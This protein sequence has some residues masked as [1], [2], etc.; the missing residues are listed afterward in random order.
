LRFEQSGEKEGLLYTISPIPWPSYLHFAASPQMATTILAKLQVGLS[1]PVI[2]LSVGCTSTSICSLMGGSPDLK[3][4][5]LTLPTCTTDSDRDGVFNRYVAEARR[6]GKCLRPRRRRV[7]AIHIFW[8]PST[9]SCA[10]ESCLVGL[11]LHIY[12]NPIMATRHSYS[13][14]PSTTDLRRPG[15]RLQHLHCQPYTRH[16]K[17]IIFDSLSLRGPR[18]QQLP[19]YPRSTYVKPLLPS[20]E[21]RG[22][23]D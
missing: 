18:E 11:M 4:R 5:Q 13:V 23:P 7:S 2:L 8:S 16:P 14:P 15:I 9:R 20:S 21:S 10:V 1:G 22:S 6:G 19:M 3:D 12:T 17:F